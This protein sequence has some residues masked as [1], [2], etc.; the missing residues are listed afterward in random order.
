M[1]ILDSNVINLP[2]IFDKRGNL[3]FI[4]SMNHIPFATKRAY[5][6]YD[7]PGGETRG[8]H[9]FKEQQ[10]FIVALSGSFDIVLNDGQT[11]ER[12]HLN[13]S[14]SGL[15]VAP[16][17]WRSMDNFSTNSV[18]LVLASTPYSE[19]D[20][21]RNYEEYLNYS[22]Q[23][24]PLEQDCAKQPRQEPEA[25]F[26]FYE[27]KV[28]DCF[29]VDLAIN[30]RD[31]GNITVAQSGDNLPFTLQRVYYLYD[32]PGGEERG[33]HAHK[34]LQQWIIAV[35]GSFDV[36]LND[37][38]NKKIVHLNRPYQALK[39]VPGIWRELNNFSSGSICLVLASEKY[40]ESDYIRD[41]Q[42]FIECKIWK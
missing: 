37:G 40:D 39:I 20:Y 28:D 41:F 15:Y 18:A 25:S 29:E 23:L 27:T 38:E 6:I 5:W 11:E 10:E 26:N 12:I 17:L 36:V 16:G 4:E 8:G 19:D 3:S 13:R 22:S 14:Y 24:N 34:K 33:G 7:V 1:I 42:E 21:I 31:K 9:A 35:S 30:H 2:K 32:I